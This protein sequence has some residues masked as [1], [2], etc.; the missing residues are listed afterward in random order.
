MSVYGRCGVPYVWL[1]DPLT[2][3]LE[4][5][6]LESGRWIVLGFYGD[7]DEVRA[8]PFQEVAI[9]LGSLWLEN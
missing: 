4:V 1:V 9:A 7:N 5:F 6:A 3:T 2:R 8:E